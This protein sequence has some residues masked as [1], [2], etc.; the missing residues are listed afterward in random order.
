MAVVY[1]KSELGTFLEQLPGLILQYQK[2]QADRAYDTNMFLLQSEINKQRE[3]E[4]QQ[5]ELA[6][7]ISSLGITTDALTKVSDEDYTFNADDIIN[8]SG[9]GLSSILNNTIEQ[10]KNLTQNISA[11]ANDTALINFTRNTLANIQDDDPA[12]SEQEADRILDVFSKSPIQK[13]FPDSDR[14]TDIIRQATGIPD[15][16]FFKRVQAKKDAR[17]LKDKVGERIKEEDALFVTRA[18]AYPTIRGKENLDDSELKNAILESDAIT[19]EYNIAD[20]FRLDEIAELGGT[21]G[22][23]GYIDQ[24]AGRYDYS[25]RPALEAGLRIIGKRYLEDKLGVKGYDDDS[26]DAYVEAA[27]RGIDGGQVVNVESGNIDIIPPN[28]SAVVLG[29]QREVDQF[30]ATAGASIVTKDPSIIETMQQRSNFVEKVKSLVFNA[31]GKEI[32]RWGDI[33]KEAKSVGFK[34]K[35]EYEQSIATLQGIQDIDILGL[36]Y[37]KDPNLRNLLKLLGVDAS[38]IQLTREQQA[39][40]EKLKMEEEVMPENDKDDFLDSLLGK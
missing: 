38:F 39:I 21:Q 12:V 3:L 34:S 29:S 23:A 18:G 33:K 36:Q 31:E 35:K 13:S 32:R 19:K 11:L 25:D 16:D 26:I 2:Q 17:P 24:V 1:R 5:S 20:P 7:R 27:L 14:A 22:G 28:Q 4:Q 30:K 6:L 10:N 9:S 40:Q 37:T 8:A 15:P